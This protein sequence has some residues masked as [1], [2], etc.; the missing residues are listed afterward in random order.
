MSNDMPEFVD[1]HAHCARKQ[2]R[3]CECSA[4]IQVGE[5]Y[6]KT[7]GVWDGE[8]SEFKQHE[9]CA[10]AFKHAISLNTGFDNEGVWYGGVFEWFD[11]EGRFEGAVKLEEKEMRSMI[12]KMLLREWRAKPWHQCECGKRWK[13]KIHHAQQEQCG[14]CYFEQLKNL[15]KQS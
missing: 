15:V 4:P 11:D 10:E 2:H 6:I 13:N 8:F 12:A 3:C 9:L 5:R 7:K 14:A 1:D